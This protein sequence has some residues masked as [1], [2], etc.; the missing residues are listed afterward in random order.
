MWGNI[1][2]G[3]TYSNTANASDQADHTMLPS[4]IDVFDLLV[5]CYRLHSSA[6]RK[7]A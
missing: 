2:V 7:A 1:L 5:D 6:V 4:G 3:P